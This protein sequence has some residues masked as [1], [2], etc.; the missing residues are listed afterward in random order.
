MTFNSCGHIVV[1]AILLCVIATHQY[2]TQDLYSDIPLGPS[3]KATIT[4]H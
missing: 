3:R 4:I 2:V 1:F